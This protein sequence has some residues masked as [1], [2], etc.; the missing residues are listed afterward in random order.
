M[1][2]EKY[3]MNLFKKVF[4]IL[5]LISIV[6]V[7]AAGCSSN[8][9]A[10]ETLSPTA[11][12]PATVKIALCNNVAPY[13][14]TNS[15]GDIAGYDYEVLKKIDEIVPEYEFKFEILDYDA[16]AIGVQTGSYALGSGAHFKTAAREEQFL[17][18]DA[19]NYFPVCL[20]VRDNS[21]ITSMEDMNGKTLV[22]VP[23]QDGLRTVFNDYMAE[24]PEANITCESG[25]SLISI[26]D[27]LAGVSTGRWDGMIDS[28]EMFASVLDQQDLPITVLD[29]FTTVGT[30][31]LINQGYGDLCEKINA[32]LVILVNDGTLPSLAEE[33]LGENTFALYDSIND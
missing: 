32:A 6:T 26:A 28:P 4:P 23:D 2:K 33:I 7:F 9:D 16:E 14:Y 22:P 18:S 29:S 10:E 21:G 5:I 8:N 30:H 11:D 13:T 19:F 27:G 24:H 25:S 20:A 17:I 15:S 31:F 3:S 12:N 1:K